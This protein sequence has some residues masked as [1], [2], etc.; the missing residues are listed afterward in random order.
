MGK[1]A[2]CGT[3]DKGGAQ[4][5]LFIEYAAGRG[6]VKLCVEAS[7][8]PGLEP[9]DAFSE[10]SRQRAAPPTCEHAPLRALRTGQ[11]KMKCPRIRKANRT[12]PAA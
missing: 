7:A 12:P 5:F 4:V 9:A 6:G 11:K 3:G 2:A 10:A 8:V 1:L